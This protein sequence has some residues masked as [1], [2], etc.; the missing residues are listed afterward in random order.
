MRRPQALVVVLVGVALG[1]PVAPAAAQPTPPPAARS[2][3]APVARG[4]APAAAA[5]PTSVRPGAP[6][7]PGKRPALKGSRGLRR[8]I[9]VDAPV[10]PRGPAGPPGSFEALLGTSED[11]GDLARTLEPFTELC[12]EDRDMTRRQCEVVRGYL[13]GV[14]QRRVFRSDHEDG[15]AGRARRKARGRWQPERR[16]KDDPQ[17]HPRIPPRIRIGEQHGI[18]CEGGPDPDEHRVV[19]QP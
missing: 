12:N 7:R 16:I 17:R 3:A 4:P 2:T 1:A 14:L 11:I 19:A 15:P 18:V 5:R 10:R 9:V 6:D 8:P 13:R